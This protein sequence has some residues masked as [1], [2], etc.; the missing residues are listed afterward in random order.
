M[1]DT[2]YATYQDPRLQP[3]PEAEDTPVDVMRRCAHSGACL[4]VMGRLCFGVDSYADTLPDEAAE[5][6]ER[7]MDCAECDEWEEA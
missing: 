6:A 5:R 1:E 2:G 7:W 3:G 4:R